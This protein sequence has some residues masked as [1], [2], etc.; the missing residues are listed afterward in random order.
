MSRILHMLSM[1]LEVQAKVRDEIKLAIRNKRAEGDLSGR[2]GYDDIMSLPWL[3]SVI[4][5]TL[6]L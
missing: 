3:D 1:H 4:K 2:L 5:E 6:R